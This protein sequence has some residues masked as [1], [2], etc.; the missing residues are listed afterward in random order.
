MHTF[1]PQT[2]A[3]WLAD[4]RA[5]DAA[6]QPWLE[7][8]ALL[9]GFD[10][11]ALLGG[12]AQESGAK[13]LLGKLAERCDELPAGDTL[14]WRLR[15]DERRRQLQQLQQGQRL[16]AAADS[17]QP[18]PGDL[19]G[20]QLRAA[21]RGEPADPTMMDVRALDEMHTALQFV[22]PLL[23]AAQPLLD[24][25]ETQLARRERDA[26]LNVL[27]PRGLVGREEQLGALHA[28][29]HAPPSAPLMLMRLQGP[30]GAGKSALLAAFAAQVQGADWRGLPVLW[31]DFDRA[32]LAG[33]DGIMV[34]LE[35]T[36]QLEMFRP[37]WRERLGAFRIGIRELL[38][39]REQI[40]QGAS[41]YEGV[42]ALESTMWSHWRASLADALPLAE[43]VLLILDTFEE[44]LVRGEDEA[45]YVLRWLLA[46][47]TDDGGFPGVRVLLSGRAVPDAAQVAAMEAS[48]HVLEVA[49]LPPGAAAQLLGNELRRLDTPALGVPTVDLIKR[50][51]G[52]PLLLKVLARYLH[53]QPDPA[54]A[55]AE[56]LNEPVAGGA[57]E[58]H[59]AAGGTGFDR[60]YAQTFL[61]R[62]ILGRIRSDEPAIEKLAHPGLVLRRVNAVLISRVLAGPCGLG[63]VDGARAAV[64]LDK[65]RR[66]VWLVEPGDH[67][68][69]VRHRRDLRRL[70]L[71]AMNTDL[72]AQA[73]RIHRRAAAFYRF[74]LDPHLPLR[75]QR[76]E[77]H[78]HAFMGA[79]FP[80]W[81][82]IEQVRPLLAY[83]GEDVEQLPLR[84]RAKL[85]V[86]AEMA[87]RADE[88]QTLDEA[89]RQVHAQQAV[90]QRRRRGT[91]AAAPGYD[92]VTDAFAAG[93]LPA[94]LQLAPQALDIFD[95]AL[96]QPTA[97]RALPG[98]TESP[99]W[100]AALAALALGEEDQ[101]LHK[102]ADRVRRV[103][104]A[105]AQPYDWSNPSGVTTSVATG[106]LMALLSPAWRPDK[107]I[108]SRLPTI[109]DCTNLRAL[110]LMAPRTKARGP[111]QI[112]VL[113][114]RDREAPLWLSLSAE[115]PLPAPLRLASTGKGQRATDGDRGP[116]TLAAIDAHVAQGWLVTTDAWPTSAEA[117]RV[118]SGRLT[119]LYPALRG[120][121]EPLPADAW[122]KFAEHQVE[123]HG[124]GWPVE[125]RPA[126]L[127]DALR[128]DA[129]RTL[130]TLIEFTDRMAQ[131]ETLL[132]HGATAA[133]VQH[134]APVE[135]MQAL[136]SRYCARLTGAADA[137]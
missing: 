101:L 82:P 43:P 31:L 62:R 118:L 16:Q 44:V 26:A 93:N 120:A 2:V 127:R 36:R 57:G 86:D 8:A 77:A 14:R 34:T 15:P 61:Y 125:L 71:P 55:T 9:G 75:E 78:Y 94:A 133:S 68:A 35:L 115:L 46:L 22:T 114:L 63:P 32:A 87:L 130:A 113:L 95:S 19:F 126:R 72:L 136:Y 10:P 124:D 28:F 76:F 79:P 116:T 59:P 112:D 1:D 4:A 18:A 69:V 128:R 20:R 67:P 102:M 99:I 66:Q 89:T 110:Q 65:L 56:L 134:Q 70:I 52:H 7:R 96:N 27:L 84:W 60:H 98:L 33:A 53:D 81:P 106:M 41:G 103:E 24:K 39:H 92:N 117:R 107:P 80:P 104:A 5:G 42:S 108:T 48:T 135:H 129:G 83:L 90:A 50:F 64:L 137:P 122:V 58:T 37:Q 88:A 30:G 51:G 74:G 23:P 47:V 13:G 49:D 105:S 85:K 11:R 131:L 12:D 91:R 97:S 121:L 21:V 17:A 109:R 40:A 38:S 25:V 119:D 54:R 6:L 45:A 111:F 132:A 29:L 73:R 3:T 123:Q 100:Q